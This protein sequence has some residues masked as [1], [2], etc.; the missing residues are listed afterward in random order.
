MNKRPTNKG[1]SYMN[2]AIP[3]IQSTH[4]V[5]FD[6]AEN[7]VYNHYFPW[8][9]HKK[10]EVITVKPTKNKRGNKYAGPLKKRQK[11]RVNCTALKTKQEKRAKAMQKLDLT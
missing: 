11:I 9:D 8:F 7:K 5:T 2:Y 1:A 10:G 6:R 3:Q 4:A